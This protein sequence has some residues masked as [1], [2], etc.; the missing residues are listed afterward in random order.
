MQHFCRHNTGLQSNED[1]NINNNI[2]SIP[3]HLLAA[4]HKRQKSTMPTQ[5]THA[6]YKRASNPKGQRDTQSHAES[7]QA[8]ATSHAATHVNTNC[9]DELILHEPG[10]L[11]IDAHVMPMKFL[12]AGAS[13]C[14]WTKLVLRQ[15]LRS[16]DSLSCQQTFPSPSC[17]PSYPFGIFHSRAPTVDASSWNLSLHPSCFSMPA[18]LI[19]H[20]LHDLGAIS[21]GSL[22]ILAWFLSIF[23]S[24]A[25]TIDASSQSSTPNHE[26]LMQ[27]L[28]TCLSL[29]SSSLKSCMI[30]ISL[31]NLS[32]LA[33]FLSIFHSKSPSIDANS[34]SS[35]PKTLRTANW[36]NVGTAKRRGELNNKHSM[37]TKSAQRNYTHLRNHLPKETTMWNTFIFNANTNTVCALASHS[38]S[39]NY[40]LWPWQNY[41][42]WF[43]IVTICHN[44]TFVAH[45]QGALGF[46]RRAEL[47]C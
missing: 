32:I 34:Q 24:K 45:Q 30:S 38:N 28:G 16:P 39:Q 22:S 29:A 42:H 31:G 37:A 11:W 2:N 26:E 41:K 1:D 19:P 43:H 8:V 27:S 36:Q 18:V 21:L 7:L 14:A 35:T 12:L 4:E 3:M 17:L 10:H 47:Q 9:N 23:H 44:W 33:S 13:W 25:L 15:Q 5:N 20:I 40:T 6:A 46:P